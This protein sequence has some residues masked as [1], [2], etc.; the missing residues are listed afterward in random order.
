MYFWSYMDVKTPSENLKQGLRSNLPLALFIYEVLV[1][2]FN[3][4]AYGLSCQLRKS[5]RRYISGTLERRSAHQ[6]RTFQAAYL[7]RQSWHRYSSCP[8]IL[9]S[10]SDWFLDKI[11]VE[12]LTTRKTYWFGCNRWITKKNNGL[13]LTCDKPEQ[14]Y[15]IGN[16]SLI[17]A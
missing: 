8:L 1:W 11:R 4:F 14:I 3:M 6:R 16:T 9:P 13:I 7:D 2:I 15:I 12:D 5:I 10:G 17:S